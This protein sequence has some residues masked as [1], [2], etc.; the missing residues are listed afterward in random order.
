M[1]RARR[2]QKQKAA[3]RVMNNYLSSAANWVRKGYE[4]FFNLH[5]NENRLMENVQNLF[6]C[7]TL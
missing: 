7:G 3:A 1:I 2:S 6:L 5:S 4:I